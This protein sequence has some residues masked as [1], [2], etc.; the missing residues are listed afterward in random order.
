MGRSHNKI[1]RRKGSKKK[2]INGNCY[3]T[4]L[5]GRPRTRWADVVQRDALK[6]LGDEKGWRG[7]AENGD[8]RLMGQAKAWKGL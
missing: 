5:V 8:E 4:R 3:T 1:G 6:L 7:R 2:V